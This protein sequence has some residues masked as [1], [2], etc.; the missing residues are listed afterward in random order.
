MTS[1]TVAGGAV[2]Y[3][4]PSRGTACEIVVAARVAVPTSAG[5]QPLVR[6]RGNSADGYG[7]DVATAPARIAF[8]PGDPTGLA[9][10]A[11][12]SSYAVPGLVT[13]SF[14]LAIYDG[15]GAIVR[16][17]ADLVIRVRVCPTSAN[18]SSEALEMG[19]CSDSVSLLPATFYPVDA[20]TGLCNASNQQPLACSVSSAAVIV[21][22][23]LAAL[24]QASGLVPLVHLVRCLPCGPGQQRKENS[25]GT[26]AVWVCA[27]CTIQQ[28]V[29]DSNNVQYGCQDCPVGAFCNGSGLVGRVPGS[30]WVPDDATGQYRLMYC[31]PGYE[32]INTDP[33]TG[34]FSSTVQAC[35]LCKA[36]YYCPGSISKG[37]ACP[38][39][40]Y[41]PDGSNSS[42]ACFEI[43]F[44]QV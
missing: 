23:S 6:L 16:G 20:V 44:V 8:A 27:D 36:R 2:Y 39:G 14:T 7:G 11:G 17:A 1:V 25:A 18:S 28:Y 26:P 9:N 40:T 34:I 5:V 13:L 43:F 41:S 12:L 29:I 22:F 21:Q 31:P 10:A 32:L 42:A 38:S 3:G 37:I 30:V 19:F 35:E 24:T 33:V 15:S 4:C